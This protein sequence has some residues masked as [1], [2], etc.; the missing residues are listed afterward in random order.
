MISGY[1][2]LRITDN[3]GLQLNPACPENTESIKIRS[4]QYRGATLDL[5]Y[6]CGATQLKGGR[7]DTMRVKL[8]DIQDEEK[9]VPLRMRSASKRT[10]EKGMLPKPLTKGAEITLDLKEFSKDHLFFIY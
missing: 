9:F 6:Q 4:F 3:Q 8:V 2:G 7:A 5:E 1:P 10:G